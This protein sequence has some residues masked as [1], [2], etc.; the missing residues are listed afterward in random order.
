MTIRNLIE[1]NKHL[2]AGVELLPLVNDTRKVIEMNLDNIG[3]YMKQFQST[4]A[5]YLPIKKSKEVMEYER[6]VKEIELQYCDKDPNG[7]PILENELKVFKSKDNYLFY[8]NGKNLLDKEYKEHISVWREHDKI[9]YYLLD[10]HELS[11]EEISLV[12]GNKPIKD[13]QFIF[14]SYNDVIKTIKIKT[15][16]TQN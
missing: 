7:N 2:R 13:K 9:V 11:D 10:N 8:L 3:Y 4:Y 12:F 1:V 6:K 5:I 15:L 14:P 16:I